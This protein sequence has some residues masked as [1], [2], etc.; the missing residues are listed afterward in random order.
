MT[1]K[2]KILAICVLGCFIALSFVPT[3]ATSAPPGKIKIGLMFGMTGAASPI[4]PL[5]LD[6]AKL[7][8]K[9]INAAG[10][11]K[12]GGKSVPIEFL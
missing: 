6:G 4:G 9:E 12:M 10:G 5:Q 7:A 8:I 3:E 2:S 1:R 11:V